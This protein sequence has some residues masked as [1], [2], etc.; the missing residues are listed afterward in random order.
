MGIAYG[1]ELT[2]ISKSFFD[3]ML[4]RLSVNGAR[5][6][7]TCNADSPYHWLKTD[8]LDNTRL[9][10]NGYVWHEKFGLDDNLSLPASKRQEYHELYRGVFKQRYIYGEWVLAEGAIY[11]DAFDGENLYDDETRPVGLL[12]QN[13]H[14]QQFVPIDYGTGNA[15]VFLQVIDDGETYWVDDEYYYDSHNFDETGGRQKTD[16][17]YVDALEGFIKPF[18]TLPTSIVDPSA[19]S[20]KAELNLRGILYEDADNDV[21]DGIR[22]TASLL[23]Q[24]KLR[25]HRRCKHLI[26]ELGT[27]AWDPKA[28]KV[29]EDKPLKQ[30]DHACDALRYFVKTRV[31]NYRVTY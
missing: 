25:I 12:Q 23:T 29:G 6:Y 31:P 27:Y 11:R 22:M 9:I 14:V 20:L 30:H 15:T 7:G 4:S 24:K 17:Q 5:L 10:N 1:D 13:G 16:R 21:L 28:Q 18:S 8:Y 2:K 26:S 19:A 3:M